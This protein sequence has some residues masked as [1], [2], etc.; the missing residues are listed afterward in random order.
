MSANIKYEIVA[1]DKLR[2]ATYD[3][4]KA[5]KRFK[6]TKCHPHRTVFFF[7]VGNGVV[8][9]KECRSDKNKVKTNFYK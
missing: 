8:A 5:L 3:Y 6:D 1:N 2:L 7:A 9:M 4:K